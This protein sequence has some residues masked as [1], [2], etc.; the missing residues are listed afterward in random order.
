MPK[1]RLIEILVN[2]GFLGVMNKARGTSLFV[3]DIPA[4]QSLGPHESK[5][6]EASDT[7]TIHPALWSAFSITESLSAKPA[8]K[9]ST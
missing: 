7:W 8:A 2:A 1:A 3:W 5:D 4:R 9:A 6:D